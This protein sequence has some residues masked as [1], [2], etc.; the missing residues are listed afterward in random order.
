MK[1]ESIFTPFLL[2]PIIAAVML[3]ACNSQK[4]P[5]PQTPAARQEEAAE[6]QRKAASVEAEMNKNSESEDIAK[7]PEAPENKSE[8]GR[9]G[10][11][12]PQ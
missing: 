10:P 9:K 3:C 1:A 5:P 12:P 11:T 4:P 6:A 2:G 7:K 8:E